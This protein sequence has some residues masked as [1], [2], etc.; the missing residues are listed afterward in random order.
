[1]KF[2]TY[3]DVVTA[4]SPSRVAS[5][6]TPNPGELLA[7]LLRESGGRYE[8]VLTLSDRARAELRRMAELSSNRQIAVVATRDTVTI[9]LEHLRDHDPET[10]RVAYGFMVER[11]PGD[12]LEKF[13]P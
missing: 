6:G 1:M 7:D 3:A 12:G 5:A 10:T 13:R 11:E 2:T 8:V 4:D 9:S